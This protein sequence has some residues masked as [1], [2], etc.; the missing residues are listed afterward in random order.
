LN[1]I[2]KKEEGKLDH[3]RDAS[4]NSSNPKI[5]VNQKAR[6]S[7]LIIIVIIMTMANA[8]VG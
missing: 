7:Q 3:E 4:I 1:I 8:L 5:G 6:A 2:L